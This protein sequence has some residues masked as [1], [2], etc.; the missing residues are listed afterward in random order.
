MFAPEKSGRVGGEAAQGRIGADMQ[1]DDAA[2]R[3]CILMGL[4][5]GAADLSAQLQSYADQ[6]HQA[7]DLVVSDDGSADAGPD[8]VKAFAG[9][10]APAGNRVDLVAGPG[11]G[12]V[13]NFLSLI[14][15]APSSVKWL[16][17]SDQDD[18]WLPD[19]LA[20][21]IACLSALPPGEPALFCSGTWITDASLGNRRPSARFDRP[22]GFRNALVQNIASG[23]TILL[24]RAAAGL[25]REA[26]PAATEI[27]GLPAHDWWLYQLVT[28]AGGSVIRDAEPTLLY[29]QH[30]RNLLVIQRRTM[31]RH[32][33]VSSMLFAIN[34]YRT[35][36]A[37]KRNL[38]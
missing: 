22:P 28:G 7:W 16:A 4:Y 15:Q 33:R 34:R 18:V 1:G 2:D 24:N 14:A 6:T 23:N 27:P 38:D 37:I 35:C 13:A 17:L 32:H 29:R 25:A 19:R 5:N 26:A 9:R 11:R 8:M 30:G 31:P 10:V 21:G 12:S 20:R 3:V 36:H